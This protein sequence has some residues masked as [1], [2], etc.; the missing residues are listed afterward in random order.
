[1]IIKMAS[2][3][4]IIYTYTG[5]ST[6]TS[7]TRSV[8]FSDFTPSGDTDKTIG[9]VLGVKF[10]CWYGTSSHTTQT[11]QGQLVGSSTISSDSTSATLS[12]STHTKVTNTFTN[13]PTA[14]ELKNL[15][16]INF[17]VGGTTATTSHPTIYWAAKSGYPM[18]LIVTF[19]DE[20]EWVYHPEILEFDVKRGTSSGT[21]T[22]SGT[23][24]LFT[25]K[26]SLASSSYASSSTLTLKIYLGSTNLQTISLKDYISTLLSG[27]TDFYGYTTTTFETDADYRFEL[28]FAC[29]GESVTATS[30]L[31]NTFVAMHIAPYSTGGVAIGD[32]STASENNPKFEVHHKSYF[33]S[34]I[35]NFRSGVIAELG[36]TSKESYKDGSVTFDRAYSSGTTPVVL[37]D[38]MSQSTAGSF[39]KCTVAVK[40]VSNTGFTFRFFNGDSSNRNP[41]FVYLAY[42]E[43]NSDNTG[44]NS[45]GGSDSGG[46]SGGTTD[47]STIATRTA[48]GAVIPGAG[49]DL[50]TTTG[51]ISLAASYV[52]YSNS[53]THAGYIK[54]GSDNSYQTTLNIPL[55]YRRTLRT[56]DYG[57]TLP[58]DYLH[59]GRIFFLKKS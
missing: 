55:P 2:T 11:F 52:N 12:S 56:E 14:T 23:K 5:Q 33:Y 25:I 24:A 48:L 50:D 40:S 9:Q 41:K 46:S 19:T 22:D 17:L 20:P 4:T 43:T 31:S 28:T 15:S 37:I 45:S 13:L 3:Y 16:T 1:M 39:G 7:K 42:A 54:F 27:V 44:G 59:T 26:L 18:K 10:E 29:N 6:W 8:S 38:F 53:N 34:G 57:D 51:K 58:T 21:V 30:W 36:N 47:I 32:L 35:E 49:F